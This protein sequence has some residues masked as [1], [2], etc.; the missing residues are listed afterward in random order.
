[1]R[2]RNVVRCVIPV[3]VVGLL[4]LPARASAQDKKDDEALKALDKVSLK[5]A[6]EAAEKESNGTPIAADVRVKGGKAEVVVYVEVGGK[7]MEVVVDPKTGAAGK[8]TEA[9]AKDERG[10]HITK[11]KD[12]AKQLA[13][14][15]V[16]L[17]TAITNA[18]KHSSGKAISI[19]PKTDGTR[20]DFTVRVKAEGKWQYVVINGETGKAKSAEDKTK[21]EQKPAQPAPAAKGG[22]GGAPPAGG[23]GGHPPSG[24]K[25][26]R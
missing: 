9:T 23:K 14:K 17:A 12:I 16:T 4:L 5:Q 21:H 10:E 22:K 13:D 1:M 6:V 11:A 2:L 25:G 24:G 18:E 26:G 15:K 8:P 19:K 7:S 20:F 3:A